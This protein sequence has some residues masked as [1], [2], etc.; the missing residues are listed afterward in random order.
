MRIFL[1]AWLLY[2]FWSLNHILFVLAISVSV[3]VNQQVRGE[4]VEAG[5]GSERV[6]NEP[7]RPVLPTSQTAIPASQKVPVRATNESAIQPH[8]A[9]P[10]KP[11]QHKIKYDKTSFEISRGVLNKQLLGGGGV[12]V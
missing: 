8:I 11:M 6:A 4:F 3:D 7:P 9:S 10:A 5:D 12:R 2:F 1:K